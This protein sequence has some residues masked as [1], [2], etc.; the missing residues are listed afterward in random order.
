MQATQALSGAIGSYIHGKREQKF[1][2]LA[3]QE[4]NL[5]I[6]GKQGDI[7]YQTR[8]R[9]LEE[10]LYRAQM[11]K[12]GVRFPGDAAAS[13]TGQQPPTAG[14]APR[15]MGDRIQFPQ[16]TGRVSAPDIDPGFSPPRRLS[17][18]LTGGDMDPGFTAPRRFAGSVTDTDVD[19]GFNAPFGRPGQFNPQTG[20]HNP[21]VPL[22]GGYSFVD[23]TQAALQHYKGMGLSDDEAA[24]A[25]QNPQ[26][27]ERI[28]QDRTT[29]MHDETPAQRYQ[30]DV[31]LENLRH[32]YRMEETGM[33]SGRGGITMKDALDWAQ[34]LSDMQ[35][36][37][38]DEEGNV[39]PVLPSQI[40]LR[41]RS[42]Y[43]GDTGAARQGGSYRRSLTARG[44]PVT[45]GG[46]PEPTPATQH[47]P[48]PSTPTPAATPTPAPAAPGAQGGGQVLTGDAAISAAADTLKAH[49]K[50][51]DTQAHRILLKH[52][53]KEPDIARVL[54]LRRRGRQP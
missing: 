54:Q 28:L 42:M 22:G 3:E 47:A 48:E 50:V 14:D 15:R 52:G 5:D 2:T 51:S 36:V 39:I 10:A 27:A 16:N 37:Q 4:A 17:G 25:A 29:M 43:Q 30:R 20:Q 40:F 7:D 26:I 13:V 46:A 6:Q 32:R 9:P 18:G 53:F 44:A 21:S 41:A 38:R 31:D 1:D 45:A 19:P 35:G 49:P 11:Y 12:Y 23:P 24:M 34:R 33:R 8:I